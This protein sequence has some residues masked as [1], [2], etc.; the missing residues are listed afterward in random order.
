MRGLVGRLVTP[1][2]HAKECCEDR[3]HKPHLLEDSRRVAPSQAAT[4]VTVTTAN[5]AL[6][7]SIRWFTTDNTTSADPNLLSTEA[8]GRRQA[9]G[10]RNRHKPLRPVEIPQCPFGRLFSWHVPGL[11]VQFTGPQIAIPGALG[12][13]G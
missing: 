9:Q 8:P 5:T 6:T 4:S 10:G 13:L 3:P 7:A 1:P 12:A 2:E 11:P